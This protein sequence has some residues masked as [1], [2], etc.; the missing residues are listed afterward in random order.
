MAKKNFKACL[1]CVNE[2]QDVKIN[3]S[4]TFN[5]TTQGF[6][7]FGSWFTKHLK[8]DAPVV[9]VVEATGSY[10]EH[11]AWFLF[12]QGQTVHVVLPN[13]AKAYMISLGQKSKNDQ[14]DARGL[15]AMGV[16]QKLDEWHP[17]SKQLYNLRGL[18]RHLEDLQ[19]LRTSLN[20]QKEQHRFGMFQV[21]EVQRSLEKTLKALDKQIEDCK[22]NIK[23]SLEKDEYLKRKAACITSIKGVSTITAAIVIGETNGFSLINNIKQ[24][25]SYS[26]YDV[27]QNQSGQKEGKTRITKKGNAHIRR[28]MHLPAFNVV[29]YKVK[30]FEDLYTRVYER[31]GIKM[32]AYVAVQRKLLSFMYILWKKEEEF[33]LDYQKSR[34]QETEPFFPV[35]STRLQK[36]TAESKETAALDRLLVN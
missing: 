8:Q 34:N 31:T 22:K 18:T 15:S 35:S 20:N 21:K 3:A 7:A 1:S 30:P 23:T 11:L 28:A 13:R 12:E 4:S 16:I 26:G 5:N 6:K 2:H 25:V 10:H 29:R 33:I 19:I 14:I 32:K 24:L 36:Q 9:F 27:K 17:I